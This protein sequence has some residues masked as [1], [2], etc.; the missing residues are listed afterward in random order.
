MPGHSSKNNFGHTSRQNGEARRILR[1]L[2]GFGLGALA[3]AALGCSSAEDRSLLSP[4]D[5]PL[6]TAEELQHRAYVISEQ[7]NDLFIVDLSTMKEVARVDTGISEEPNGNHMSMLSR[8]GSK[9]YVSA[10]DQGQV[11]VVDARTLQISKTIELGSHPT[12]SEACFDCPPFGRD[13]LWV[14][15]EEGGGPAM[16]P[17]DQ[18]STGTG[19]VSI[20]DMATDEVV[21]T[22]ADPS[23]RVP[24]FARFH[25]RSAYIPSIGG[26]QIS[27]LDLDT[28]RVKDVLLLDGESAPG[29]CSGDPC[30]FADAQIDGNGLLV[31]AHI[32]TGHVLSY[33]TVAERRRPD[34]LMGNRPWSI[35][36]DQLSNE[37]NT[38]LMPNWG[39]QTVSV[40]DRVQRKEIARSL[41]GDQES[42]GI[43]YSP[44]APG[45]AFVLN[46]VKERVAVIDRST[47]GL[48]EA[49]D[50]GGTTETAST[51][52]DGR[53]LLLPLSSTD[54]FS[55]LD[56]TT[57]K[58]VARFNDVG[59]YPWS[60]TTVGGQNYCH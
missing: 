35:F 53:Y 52:Q 23:F 5:V 2:H 4:M 49:I 44:L 1:R 18:A 48:L 13:E 14:V 11:V 27:V 21:R 28:Y 54:Q 12:H 31:A 34:L 51:T 9:I 38:H 55:V 36:V 26:N 32:E 22:I 59:V 7:S 16:E 57:H 17:E 15:N 60:V 6:P 47:G 40:I 41:E 29:A 56:V 37:F 3:L 42:F 43:N 30:G 25:D 45:Q 24:H 39:D 19:S 58:E 33:D 10:A 50:V 8:D 46:R 20:I